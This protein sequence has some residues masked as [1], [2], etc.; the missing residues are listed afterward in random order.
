MKRR[1]YLTACGVGLASLAGCTTVAKTTRADVT[2]DRSLVRGEGDPVATEHPVD[3][4]SVEYL[5]E[6][7]EVRDGGTTQPF[8]RWARRKCETVGLA[9]VVPVIEERF[10]KSIEGVGT[11]VRSLL[12][13]PVITVDYTIVR[14][15]DGS[16][17]REPNVE[18]EELVAVTPRRVTATV[19][20]EGRAYTRDVPVAARR[21]EVQSLRTSRNGS[22]ES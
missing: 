14:D 17:T 3:R 21:S 11:G 6:T 12:F 22:W 8:D 10:G 2:A 9:A 13:G 20:L 15:S 19:A 5:E 4:D 1:T 16:V 18:F 7:N